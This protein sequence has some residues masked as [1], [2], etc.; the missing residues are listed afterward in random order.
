MSYMKE[1]AIEVAARS[2]EHRGY[3]VIETDWECETC[4]SDLIANDGGVLVFA[5]VTADA[6]GGFPPEVRSSE[7]RHAREQAAL[8][9]LATHKGS[10]MTIRFDDLVLVPI[11]EERYIVRHHINVLAAPDVCDTA[12]SEAA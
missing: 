3:D 6:E 4:G 9:Y 12:L 8:A 5:D 2:L 11:D 10:D 7:R 1:R